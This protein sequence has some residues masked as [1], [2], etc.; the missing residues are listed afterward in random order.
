MTKRSNWKGEGRQAATS[1]TG[2]AKAQRASRNASLAGTNSSR[3]HRQAAWR[4]GTVD[5][6]QNW[7]WGKPSQPAE[8]GGGDAWQ[9]KYR[10]WAVI[11]RTS[12]EN[13]GVGKS[14]ATTEVGGLMYGG[15]QGLRTDGGAGT[16]GVSKETGG[17]R[18]GGKF[19]SSPGRDGRG[20]NRL[21]FGV[22]R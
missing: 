22:D 3:G 20:K 21:R 13:L 19:L 11:E 18:G 17:R 7:P 1:R 16:V 15:E 10:V 2:S 14:F 6:G 4:C 8:R 5:R 9:K 12:R